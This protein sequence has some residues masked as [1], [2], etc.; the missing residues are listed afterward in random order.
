MATILSKYHRPQLATVR[1]KVLPE[2]QPDPSRTGEIIETDFDNSFFLSRTR[3]LDVV[4][5]MASTVNI[6]EANVI[7]AGGRALGSAENFNILKELADVLGGTIGA[8]RVV[9]DN[10]IT[11]CIHETAMGAE[12]VANPAPQVMRT[13]TRENGAFAVFFSDALNFTGDDV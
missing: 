4:E 13:S 8:S 3:V 9:V 1:H 5:E 12:P 6:S 10:G 11:N 7:V 2:S